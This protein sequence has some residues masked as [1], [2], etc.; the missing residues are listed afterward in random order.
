MDFSAFSCYSVTGTFCT[1]TEP[2]PE[3]NQVVKMVNICG[4]LRNKRR[5]TG[6][7]DDSVPLLINCC[8]KQI[9]QTQDYFLKRENGRLDY[10]LI[11]I[12]KGAGHFCIDGE[13]KKLAAGS[14]VL[15]RPSVPQFYSYYAQDKPEVY[16]IHFTGNQCEQILERYAVGTCYIGENFSVKLLFQYIITELQLKKPYYE[17]V[18]L[19]NFYILLAKIHRSFD[20]TLHHSENDFSLDRLIREINSKYMENWTVASMA[21]FC[22]LSESYF[23]HTFKQRMGVPPMQFLNNLRMEKAKEFLTANSMSVA[24]VARLVG[25]E[26]PLYFSRVFRKCTGVAPHKFYQSIA[27][28]NTPEWFFD[29][30]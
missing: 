13:W 23:S 11:Y 4:H 19:E 6:F 17:D 1:A 8:G 14:I 22:K 25:Y 15:F 20:Q 18:I 27:D 26:D 30:E 29:R 10:Q 12:Y 7:Y 2:D 5:I 21:D 28:A 24:T 3:R 9:F 16:W